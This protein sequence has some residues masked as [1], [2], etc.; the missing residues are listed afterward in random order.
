M[1]THHNL[2]TWLVLATT[3]I[4]MC[5]GFARGWAQSVQQ[6]ITL[7]YKGS[8]PKTPMA[9]VSVT[10]A[11]AGSVMS[12]DDGC[13]E[14]RFRTLRTGDQIQF[15]RIELNGYEVMNTEALEV[16]RVAR[17]EGNATAERLAIVMAPTKMLRQLRDGYR[18]VAVE[19]YKRQLH[20]AE[21]EAEK[22]RQQ[23]QLQEQEFNERLDALE[24]EYDEKLNR[25]ESYIDKF[26]RI[27]LSDIDAD[28][29]HIV[30]LVQAGQFDEA[31]AIYDRQD[32]AARLRQSRADLQR[33]TDARQQITAAE[34]QKA[35]ENLRL[36]Q[37][38]DRQI[39]LLRM[40]GGEDNLQKVYRL[41]HETFLADTTDWEARRDYAKSLYEQGLNP[42]S[43]HVLEAG[44]AT[45]TNAL[46]RGMMYLDL[47]DSRWN[48]DDVDQALAYADLAEQILAPL[49]EGNYTVYT[50]ALPAYAFTQL[51]YSLI[52][53]QAEKCQK[54]VSNIQEHWNPDTLN[55][56][57]LS[58][59]IELLGSMTDHYSLQ[60]D[61]K[62]SLWCVEQGIKLGQCMQR[63]FPAQSTLFEIYAAAC[64]TY[65]LE[66][67]VEQATEAAR[68]SVRLLDDIVQKR[69]PT[70][71]L[72]DAAS[73]LF[74]IS[75][76]LTYCEQ[77][78]LADS[79]IR[80][81]EHH[82]LFRD[83]ETKFAGTNREVSGC[84]RLAKVAV[85]L[86]NGQTADAEQLANEAFGYLNAEQNEKM[87][88]LNL[89]QIRQA[90]GNLSEAEQYYKEAIRACQKLN[91]ESPSAWITDD[92][93]TCSLLLAQLYAQQGSRRQSDQ[94]IKQAKKHAVFGYNQ[95]KLDQIRNTHK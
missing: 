22:L 45:T 63:Q 67:Q 64:S 78:A 95:Q 44:I 84:Y 76:A 25:L 18:S 38:I 77:Y 24:A 17:Q 87:R 30:E 7:E 20:E 73:S 32:L 68:N 21:A 86:H 4:L 47:M 5:C 60:L 36:R 56:S 61:H 58:S 39:T 70:V 26:A 92:I 46:A 71:L 94:M 16:A 31:L 82:Q 1:N 80:Y 59:Y 65:A 12:G 28:E 35:Q 75:E 50:R 23:G 54:V 93:C 8:N 79:I 6:G 2:H 27:D 91:A 62:Q 14:L 90:Q 52:D 29:Q 37:S 40:A 15:R 48:A 85:L 55:A 57:S 42:E 13:F 41:Y 69:I 10:A 83:F 19:R 11:N 66:G 43:E 3:A 74:L 89:G 88:P 81:E 51:Q 9:G 33:L 49:A 34:Q 53:G 72:H